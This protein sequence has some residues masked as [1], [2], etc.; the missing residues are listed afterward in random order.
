MKTQEGHVIKNILAVLV[1]LLFCVLISLPFTAG[2]T[3][4]QLLS[5]A[6]NTGCGANFVV[7]QTGHIQDHSY[8]TWTCDFEV[9]GNVTAGNV[10]IDGSTSDGLYDT[11]GGIMT[12]NLTSGQL[13]ATKGTAFVSGRPVSVMRACINTLNGTNAVANVICSGGD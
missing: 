10:R 5:G 12:I 6:N 9:N 4:F 8:S 2:A 13:S 3:D 1:I 7:T 11:T